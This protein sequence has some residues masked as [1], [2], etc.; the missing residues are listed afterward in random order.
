MSDVSRDRPLDRIS[1]LWSVVCR[2]QGG[3]ADE[4]AEANRLLLERYGTAVRRY[5]MGAVRDPDAADDLFQEFSL[6]LLRGDLK[7]A[8][9]GRGRFRHFVKGVLGHLVADHHRGR[10]RTRQVPEGAPEPAAPDELADADREFAAG[11]REQMLDG[12]W[13]AL[14][15]IECRTGQPF[16]AVL[17]LRADRPDLSSAGMA[18]ELTRALGKSISAAW[19]R[20]NLHRAREK[21]VDLIVTEVLQTLEGPTPDD[22]ERELID[23]NLYEYCRDAAQRYRDGGPAP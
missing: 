3:P 16:H 19:V 22:L 14:E 9:P 6:R 17:R 21:Y 13:K 2:A 18:E 10:G 12:A 5:L 4:A 15:L 8:D 1:T 11:W 20:Q 23:L 7:R